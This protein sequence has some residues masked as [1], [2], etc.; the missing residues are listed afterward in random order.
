MAAASGLPLSNNGWQTSFAIEGRPKPAPGDKP[1]MEA[2]TVTP[3]YF[4]TMNIPLLRGRYFTEHDDRS[5]I[6]GKDLSQLKTEGE[7]LLA[8]TNVIIID[9][10]FAKRYWPNEDA[11]GKH[12][13]K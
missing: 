8:G 1:L 12:I 7:R 4:R 13:R 9:E 2:C 3:D 10:Q 5:F 11:V 6:A